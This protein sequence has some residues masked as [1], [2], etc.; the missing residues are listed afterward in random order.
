MVR[1]SV[2]GARV[3]GVAVVTMAAAWFT[4]STA[5]GAQRTPTSVSAPIV[6]AISAGSNHTCAVA[7]GAAKCW[8]DNNLGQLGTGDNDNSPTPVGVSG[9]DAAVT[10]IVASED[11]TCAIQDGAVKCWGNN[12]FGKLGDGGST[13][14]NTPV[15]VSGLE[16]GVTAIAA[17]ASHTCAIQV[18]TVKCW[19]DNGFGQLGNGTTEQSL[20]PVE[21]SGLGSGVIAISGGTHTACAIDA[22]GAAK[23]WGWNQFGQLGDDGSTDSST[24]VGVSGLG[25][26]V[27][28]I[29]N[30]FFNTCAIQSGAVKCWG[31]N[32]QGQ[33]GDGTYTNSLVPVQV[34]GL[35]FGATAIATGNNHSC[36]VAASGAVKCWGVNSNETV[37]GML[38][39][40]TTT[41][42][43][44][45]VSASGLDSG[46]TAV[47]VGANHSCAIH[48]GVAKCWGGNQAGQ[49]G[50][51]T[52]DNRYTPVPVAW[53]DNTPPSTSVVEVPVPEGSVT[54]P[55][56]VVPG[57]KFKVKARCRNTEAVTFTLR[58]EKRT[59]TCDSPV[60]S[61]LSRPSAR[62]YTGFAEVE[63]TA[64]VTP[65]VYE[66]VV[67][68]GTSLERYVLS[69]TV[70][71]ETTTGPTVSGPVGDVLPATGRSNRTTGV[72]ITLLVLG[73]AVTWLGR[74]VAVG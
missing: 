45:P 39:D 40:G 54:D 23:C 35:D 8:G 71:G 17:G 5:W 14:S 2:R 65:G 73:L 44:V 57:G 70:T 31:V 3:L 60:T 72:A 62:A 47:A 64:P 22:A 48:E 13:L 69:V 66:V 16:S 20:L 38:G 33:L 53:P 56:A 6:T 51:G 37:E 46:V 63:F 10:A 52:T 24:P 29:A 32:W 11:H 30:R 27:T 59:A 61:G 41:D 58:E 34:S 43:N 1:G 9:L 74:R 55:V 15:Q 36:A 18:R 12:D 4:T 68:L 26:G 25:S 42:S 67:E 49:L 50:D 21:V 28:A 19:G 7:D